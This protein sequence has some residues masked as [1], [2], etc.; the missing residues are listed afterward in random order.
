MEYDHTK[1]EGEITESTD[2]V[3][4]LFC[5]SGCQTEV[6]LQEMTQMDIKFNAK[7]CTALCQTDLD[8]E[9][10]CPGADPDWILWFLEASHQVPKNICVCK[11][12]PSHNSILSARNVI[13]DTLSVN[14]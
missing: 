3:S 5:N 10:I 12:T 1:L 6:T 4:D 7:H 8:M 9:T 14:L 13:C 2:D 11:N